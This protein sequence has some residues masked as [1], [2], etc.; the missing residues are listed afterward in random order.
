MQ[1]VLTQ[2]GCRVGSYLFAVNLKISKCSWLLPLGQIMPRT[3]VFI[4]G[5]FTKAR[6]GAVWISFRM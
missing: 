4:A 1:G 2:A 5:E 6:Y 3:C